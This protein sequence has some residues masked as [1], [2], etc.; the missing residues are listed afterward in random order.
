M[1]T[2]Q[3]NHL[4]EENKYCDETNFLAKKFK[5]V[6]FRNGRFDCKEKILYTNSIYL[7]K[8]NPVLIIAQVEA[9]LDISYNDLPKQVH[10]N[11]SSYLIFAL[12][13]S[14]DE[15][16]RFYFFQLKIFFLSIKRK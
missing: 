13:L 1:V 14:N 3:Y 12:I 7:L 11:G 5:N 2:T 8:Q 16:L 4:T 9:S 10:I 6:N 15:M